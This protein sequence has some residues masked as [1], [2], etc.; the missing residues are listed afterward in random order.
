M[1][2]QELG[3]QAR[4]AERPQAGYVIA[5]AVQVGAERVQFA[6][7]GA[8]E[9]ARADVPGQGFDGLR[10]HAPG[11]SNP[12]R[13][14]ESIARAALAQAVR[15]TRTAPTMVSNGESPGHQPCGPCCSRS[16]S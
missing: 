14:R 6:R 1:H 5:V 4:G 15:W 9:P 16:S 12:V 11:A 2:G 3:A 13:R 7:L 8:K 10:A